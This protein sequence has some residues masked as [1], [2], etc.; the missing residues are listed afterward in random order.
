MYDEAEIKWKE[1]LNWIDNQ[2]PNTCYR[3]HSDKDYLLLP[4]VGRSNY[5]LDAELNMFEHFKRKIS[6]YSNAKNEYEY[7]AL[8]QH[9]GLPTRLLDWTENPLVACYFAV[10]HRQNADA[11]IYQINFRNDDFVNFEK[12]T[13]PF[14]LDKINFLYPPIS[15]KRIELQ[16]GLFTIHPL[17]NFPV[18]IGSDS[19]SSADKN[20]LH[21]IKLYRQCDVDFE[22]P[23]FENGDIIENAL[24]F[25]KN[26]YKD[27]PPYF[28]IPKEFKKYFED[29]VRLLGIDETIFGDIDSIAKNIVYLQENKLLKQVTL[30]DQLKVLPFWKSKIPDLIK[31]Y[32]IKNSKDFSKF[33]PFK[34]LHSQI[35][36]EITKVVEKHYNMKEIYGII[37]YHIRPNYEK[38]DV[39]IFKNIFYSEYETVCH[40]IYDLGYNPPHGRIEMHQSIKLD[41]FT[42]GFKEN[43]I[44]IINYHKI[45]DESINEL[46]S[47]IK[48]TFVTAEHIM[49]KFMSQISIDDFETLKKTVPNTSIYTKL[50]DKYKG[51]IDFA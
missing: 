19:I 44:S 23:D 16:K 43:R 6:L 42:E 51:N 48:I 12:A 9:H 24:K 5:S 18:I 2:S 29:K 1:F 20:F 36:F 21:P 47:D 46:I 40:F 34:I 25:S 13:S 31:V 10:Y 11:R 33:T 7:L 35:H 4:K 3:G 14:H 50:L 27:N 45:D 22:I 41:L 39:S 17:P 30:S 15:T 28:D 38:I 49:E 37:Y 8:A 26:Y 32:F